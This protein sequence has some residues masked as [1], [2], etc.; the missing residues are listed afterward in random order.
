MRAGDKGAHSTVTTV[1]KIQQAKQK[2]T[3]TL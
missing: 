3:V 1:D 2:D